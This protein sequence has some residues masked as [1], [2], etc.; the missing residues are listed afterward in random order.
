MVLLG[1]G[2]YIMISLESAKNEFNNKLVEVLRKTPPS[3]RECTSYL[4]KSLGKNLRGNCILIVASDENQLVHEDAIN[5]AVAIELFH[6]ATLV[7]DDI[8]DDSPKWRGMDS[9]QS[10]FDKKT[11]VIC[12]DYILA[13]A[14]ELALKVDIKDEY[15]KYSLANYAKSVCLG[16]LMQ[17]TNLFN[18]NLSL[19]RYLTIIRGKTAALFEAAFVSGAIV[20]GEPKSKVD[21]YKNIGRYIGMIFQMSDDCMDYELTQAESNKPVLSDIAK[22]VITL[23]LI[24]AMKKNETIREKLEQG[25][26]KN[27]LA[28]EIINF[29]GVEFTKAFSDR[30]YDKSIVCLDKL[31]ISSEKYTMIKNVLDVA[32]R[33]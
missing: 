9:L 16:E 3:I 21:L 30:Y 5:L 2:I 6:L 17:D 13:M 14:I 18:Y 26:D 32:A 22:G 19:K 12:G 29:G 33:R 31:E 27:I 11:A 8:I 24:Y 7:H 1:S 28:R 15:K 20:L 25:Y 4:S 23:P 10:R